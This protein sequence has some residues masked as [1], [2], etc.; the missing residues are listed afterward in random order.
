MFYRQNIVDANIY[1]IQHGQQIQPHHQEQELRH[2]S[3]I[4]KI[5]KN[6]VVMFCLILHNLV[7]VPGFSLP[8]HHYIDYP[9]DTM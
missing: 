4:S 5:Y 6:T 8:G 3:H 2:T 9:P 7:I 1:Q